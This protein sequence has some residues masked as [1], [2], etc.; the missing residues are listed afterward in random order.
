[1]QP[2]S[3]ISMSQSAVMKGIIRYLF[4]FLLTSLTTSSL[5]AYTHPDLDVKDAAVLETLKSGKALFKSNCASC[6]AVDRKLIGPAMSGVWDRWESQEKIIAWVKNSSALIASGDAYANKIFNE[7]NKSVMSAYPDLTDDQILSIISYAYAEVNFKGWD[8]TGDPQAIAAVAATDTKSEGANKWLLIALVL[9]LVIMVA[10][11][12][13]V[14][15]R[16]DNLVKEQEGEP[17]AEQQSL[18]KCFWTKKTKVTIGLIIGIAFVFN[19]AN[20]AINLQ[21]QQGYAPEQPIK[22]SHQ[23]H[24]GQLKIDCQYC[25]SG[26]RKDKHANIPSVNVCMNC[27]KYV[28]QGPKYGETE[29][30]KIYAASG[31]DPAAQ[32]YTKPQQP[33]KWVRIHNLPDHVYFNHSQHVVAG[34]VACQTCHG[35]VEEYEL[36]KQFSPLSMGWCINCHRQTEVQFANNN[37]YSIFEKYHEEIKNGKKNK[38]NVA[39]IGGLECQQ[40]HY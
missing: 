35:K 1:L 11:L 3:A 32:A 33:V 26:A 12:W 22:Y 40:C 24:A 7:N 25:H 39:D 5:F 19:I 23:L 30:A 28:Q 13:A 34:G 14:T 29:I 37:Y 8:A 2:K 21:R 27:H 15:S 16:L 20:G 10:G 17:I 18:W 9:L 36:M 4:L 31:W 38:V 6:H